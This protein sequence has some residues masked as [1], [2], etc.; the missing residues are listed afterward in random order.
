MTEK[1]WMIVYYVVYA[2][3]LFFIS[4]A[5]FHN[6]IKE[7]VKYAAVAVAYLL[8]MIPAVL[9]LRQYGFII[10]ALN[11][12]MFLLLFQGSI[13]SRLIHF[14]VVYLLTNM[15]E[16]LIFCIGVICWR[17]SPKHW[18]ISSGST[19]EISLV[20]A[21]VITGLLLYL[22]NKKVIQNFIAYFRALNWFQYLMITLIVWSGIFLMGMIAVMPE[23]ID[24]KRKSDMLFFLTVIFMGTAFV[25][26]ISLVFNVYGKDYYL[27][28]NQIKEEIIHVQQAY[29][30]NISDNEREMRRFRHDISSQL[31]CLGLFLADG[32]TEEALDYLRAIGNHFEELAV[33][34]YYTGNEVLD[35]I[36]NQK[37]LEISEKG[38]EIELEGKMD[39]PDFMDTYDLCMIFSNMLDNGI[40]ACEKLQDQEAVIRVSILTHGDT[41]FF[42]FANPATSEMYE[43]L[44][45]GRTTKDDKRNHGFGMENVK[46]A[47]DRNG[48]EIEYLYREGKLV[49]E[50]YF[51]I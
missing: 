30:Q 31:R 4:E 28:Q 33:R 48:G 15:M 40:E 38:I 20:F 47:L 18:R 49:V 34:K 51:E 41:V 8:I 26:I 14:G 24:N 10:M 5:I 43:A 44:K 9:F 46:R 21:A 7:K 42:Q 37:M 50:M 2:L 36:I 12:L 27:K 25:G 19:G 17:L 45:R 32:K 16:S 11:I 1:I 39:Q 22:V 29:F 6:R 3:E 13:G 35:L 23:Y